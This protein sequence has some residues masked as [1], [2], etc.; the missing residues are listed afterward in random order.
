MINKLK[1]RFRDLP[2]YQKLVLVFSIIFLFSMVLVVLT[3]S[4]V[5]RNLSHGSLERHSDQLL[6][7]LERN[8]DYILLDTE[9]ISRFV[10]YDD[11]I[12]RLLKTEQKSDEYVE[13]YISTRETLVNAMS[14]KNY[15][16][17]ISVYGFDGQEI[18]AGYAPSFATDYENIARQP[19]FQMV[20]D[21]K[22]MYVWVHSDFGSGD[23]NE[24]YW[25]AMARVV[26]DKQTIEPCGVMVILLN[27]EHLDN[28][29]SQAVGQDDIFFCIT[30]DNERLVAPRAMADQS[31][32]KSLLANSPLPKHMLF[33]EADYLITSRKM[34]H[35]GWT[36]VH[37]VPYARLWTDQSISVLIILLMT[38]LSMLLALFAYANFARS[39]TQPIRNIIG[40]MEKAKKEDFKAWV[41]VGRRDEVGH[42]ANAY[43]NLLEHIDVLVNDVLRERLHSQQA[44]LE[45]LQAQI[46]PHFLYNTLDC[47]NWKA[48]M[49]HEDEISE[50]IT[51]LS[52]M[53]R[54]SLS[55]NSK[56]VSLKEEL[57]NVQDYLFIQKM[58]FENSLQTIVDIQPECMQIKVLKYILQPIVENSILHGVGKH[59]G[60]GLVCI[61]AEMRKNCVEVNISDNGPGVDVDYITA[62][63]DNTPKP[64]DTKLHRHGIYNVNKRMKLNYGEEYGLKYSIREGGGTNVQITIPTEED[65][66][67]DSLY[68]G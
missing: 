64:N 19:W 56:F 41:Q 36:L 13:A 26:N 23:Q 9:N 58:R 24:R 65:C 5:T 50:M 12:Q 18:V 6:H 66:D 28:I 45:N 60:K 67:A 55:G 21:K 1:T 33:K 17:A 48:M 54:F 8:L 44:E 25:V 30:E 62:L 47:I 22:G 51:A 11:R 34:E 38:V 43:N 37:A 35:L 46:N 3:S 40:A 57:N 63:L 29:L 31:L 68:C 27:G 14:F 20:L 49:N 61:T 10:I 15:I 42:L 4:V 16:E 52:N 7:E 53:F 39:I 32:T 59:G 2:L